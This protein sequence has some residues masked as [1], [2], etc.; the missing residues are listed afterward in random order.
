MG[1]KKAKKLRDTL[2][3]HGWLDKLHPLPDNTQLATVLSVTVHIPSS[4]MSSVLPHA[5]KVNKLIE[6]GG[7]EHY[8]SETGKQLRLNR[9]L[10]GGESL[11]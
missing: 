9:Q 6:S 5:E 10:L 4:S 7:K 2:F 11:Y 3:E 1:R 8:P